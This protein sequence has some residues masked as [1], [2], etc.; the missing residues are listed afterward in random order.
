MKLLLD[1]NISPKVAIALASQDGIDACAIRDRGLLGATD[2]EVLEYAYSQDRI[3]VTAN[4]ADFLKLARA[5][6][7]HAGII[8]LADGA[9]LGEQQLLYVRAAIAALPPNGDLV[10]KVLWVGPNGSTQI[11]EIPRP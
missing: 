4:I 7:I 3:L 5:R 2:T 6:E 8:L 1:E 10:N 11:E 9:G